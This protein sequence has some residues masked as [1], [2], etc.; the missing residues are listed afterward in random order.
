MQKKARQPGA[1]GQN[2]HMVSM[3]PWAKSRLA[4]KDW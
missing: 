1:A 3:P 4:N 2:Y